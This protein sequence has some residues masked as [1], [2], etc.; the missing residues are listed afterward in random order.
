MNVTI[1]M[2]K[3]IMCNLPC[4]QLVVKSMCINKGT[5]VQPGNKVARETHFIQVV[6]ELVSDQKAL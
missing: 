4:V 6:W 1:S 3:K 5:T 2:R